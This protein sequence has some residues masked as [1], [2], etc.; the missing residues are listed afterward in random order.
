MARR[1]DLTTDMASTDSPPRG[2]SIPSVPP[3]VEVIASLLI[4][5]RGRVSQDGTSRPLSS[6]LDHDRFLALR[7]WGSCIVVGGRTFQAESYERSRL[8]VEVFSRFSREVESWPEEIERL[9]AKHGRHILIEAGPGLLHQLLDAN[10][11]DRLYLTRTDRLSSDPESPRFDLNRL[12]RSMKCID[13]LRHG[14]DLFEI[15]QKI[16]ST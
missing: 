8:P 6:P 16:Q 13:S 10:L 11:I 12:E 9:K 1:L 5:P 3:Q 7:T 4:D 15:H 14:E 2:G